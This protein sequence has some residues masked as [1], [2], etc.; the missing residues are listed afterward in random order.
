MCLHLGNSVNQR[1]E[2]AADSS[3]IDLRLAVGKWIGILLLSFRIGKEN[4]ASESGQ[5]CGATRVHRGRG[6]QQI[7]IIENMPGECWTIKEIESL[8]DQVVGNKK[9]PELCIP[10]KSEAA[11]NNQRRRLK[12]AGQLGG[13]FTGR[14]LKPWTICELNELRKFSSEC[15]FS[16]DFISCIG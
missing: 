4:E 16:A 8:I 13:V 14:T 3:P 6:N 1:Q 15:R 2:S 5:S 7:E 11:V 9:L 10:G 12:E